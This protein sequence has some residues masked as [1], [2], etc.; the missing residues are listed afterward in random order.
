ME[1]VRG[2][3]DMLCWRLRDKRA[4]CDGDD[5]DDGA[6]DEVAAVSC[7]IRDCLGRPEFKVTVMV[8]RK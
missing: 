5:D 8:L 3:M 6:N 1:E 2:D 7:R 4:D